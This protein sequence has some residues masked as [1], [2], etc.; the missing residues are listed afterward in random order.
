SNTPR[1]VAADAAGDF[2]AARGMAD[3]DRVLQVERFDQCRQVV[4]VRVHCVAIP[5]LARPSVAATVMGDAAIAAGSQKQH[6]VFPRVRAEWPAVAE[7]DGLSCAPVL[8]VDP[9]AVLGNDRARK[10]LS[11][12]IFITF[13][14]FSTRPCLSAFRTFPLPARFADEA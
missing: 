11:S 2:T 6:L 13:S 9:C 14:Y 10:A 12:V 8:V 5:G 7:D 3:V 1:A 4:G